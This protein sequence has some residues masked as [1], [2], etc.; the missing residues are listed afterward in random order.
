M[1]TVGSLFSGCLVDEN[2]VPMISKDGLDQLVTEMF[3]HCKKE[4][5]RPGVYHIRIPLR[6]TSPGV[7]HDEV[8]LIFPDVAFKK[9]SLVDLL[10]N[11]TDTSPGG[12]F[13]LMKS[14]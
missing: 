11:F 10:E 8:T 4:E 6:K 9:A 13:S 12:L 1:Q 7:S 5:I 2:G 3:P 14:E